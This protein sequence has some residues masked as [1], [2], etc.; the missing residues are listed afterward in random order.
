VILLSSNAVVKSNAILGKTRSVDVIEYAGVI[1][2]ISNQ[3]QESS[4]PHWYG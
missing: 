3:N 4:V 2:M 1:I